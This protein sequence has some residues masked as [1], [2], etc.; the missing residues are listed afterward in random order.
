MSLDLDPM[1]ARLLGLLAPLLLAPLLL[2]DCRSTTD[3]GT[4]RGEGPQIFFVG[5]SHT[6]M[7]DVPGLVQALAD[8]SGVGPVTVGAIAPGGTALIDHWYDRAARTTV[9]KCRG[10]G[11][12]VLQQGWTPGG[13]WRDTLLIATRGFASLVAPC[14][15]KVV[16][17]QV[18]PPI[19]RPGQFDAS[20]QS[21]AI[22]AREVDGLL[23]PVAE[24]WLLV[25]QR[26]ASI[27]L[28]AGDGLHAS[29][30]GY[31]LAAVTLY[32][33]IFSRSPVG[34]PASVRTRSGVTIHLAPATALTLQQ[35][36]LD[37]MDA[38]P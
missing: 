4:A 30:A 19:D 17:Y 16:M 31:Y 2:A 18:W 38:T 12:L 14:H 36:A 23:A 24:A 11:H 34:L 33:R 35:A 29:Q 32:A 26:D 6:S 27:Q 37:A 3:P 22:A 7:S 8:S 9:A 5:N 13:V 28:Y 1:H 20:I 25:Q 15:T 21:F 10:M